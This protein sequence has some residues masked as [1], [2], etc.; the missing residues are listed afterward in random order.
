[1]S[2]KVCLI[3][4][5]GFIVNSETPPCSGGYDIASTIGAHSCRKSMTGN[6]FTIDSETISDIVVCVYVLRKQYHVSSIF[7][8][9]SETLSHTVVS[10]GKQ[11]NRVK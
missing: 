5:D 7:T 9:D 6:S 1:M 3:V 10:R 11:G 8:V 4:Q 2:T